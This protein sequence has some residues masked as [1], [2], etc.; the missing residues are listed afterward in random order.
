M[1]IFT[2][3]YDTWNVFYKQTGEFKWNRLCKSRRYWYADPILIEWK[4]RKY[5]F[6]EAYDMLLSIGRIAVTEWEGG[7]FS[8]P[9]IILKRPY[10]LSYP[11]VFE[12]KN[13]LYMLPE[14][15]QNGTLELY[16]A[17]NG[18]PYGWKRVKVLLNQVMYADSTVVLY[19]DSYYVI[20]Y[21][22]KR[23]E[24][25]TH[26]F[27]LDMEKM[28]I[29][30]I[31]TIVS[32]ENTERPAGKFFDRE[33]DMFRPTQFNVEQY[34]GGL[35][36]EK[37]NSLTPFSTNKIK[38]VVVNNLGIDTLNGSGGGP[39]TLAIDR[40]ICVVDV[41]ISGRNYFAFWIILLRK[42]RNLFYKLKRKVN[43]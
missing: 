10:H 25:K 4:G 2:T 5:L 17:E 33:N 30:P 34:G 41:L 11:L 15:G 27:K 43:H 38:K 39:H 18:S 9:K 8:A 42:V 3:K 19:N 14:T 21:E 24:W 12:Y 13:N 20:A 7:A 1:K 32:L 26:I 23:T 31:E 40:D 36:I 35:I 37:V 29:D 6:V 16:M 22:E 28:E